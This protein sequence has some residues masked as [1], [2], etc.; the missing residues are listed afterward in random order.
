MTMNFGDEVRREV[1]APE[2][3]R[4]LGEAANRWVTFQ[5]VMALVGVGLALL[6]ILFFFLPIWSLF[7]G[8]INGAP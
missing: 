2:G 5:M 1:N 6:M 3:G 7:W 8:G 4:T